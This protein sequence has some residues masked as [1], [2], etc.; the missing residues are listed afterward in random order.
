MFSYDFRM[1]DGTPVYTFEDCRLMPGR[2]KNFSGRVDSYKNT[3]KR[4]NVIIDD[5]DLARKMSEEGWNVK[6]REGREEEDV[7]ATLEIKIN[8]NVQ[9]DSMRPIVKLMSGN[10]QV[11]LDDETIGMLDY[12]EIVHLDI[13]FVG[14]WYSKDGREGYSTWLRSMYVTIE[15]DP[16]E[17]KYR[18]FGEPAKAPDEDIPF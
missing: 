14:R 12:A 17:A 18:N 13:R 9:Y 8:F 10:S 2:F 7:T 4:F 11:L 5:L 1:L 6:F 15:E 16:L 3:R